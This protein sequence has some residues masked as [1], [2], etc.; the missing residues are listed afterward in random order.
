MRADKET[1]FGDEMKLKF[2]AWSEADRAKWVEVVAKVCDWRM[3][4][5][6]QTLLHSGDGLRAKAIATQQGLHLNTV[7]DRLYVI[8]TD[9]AVAATPDDERRSELGSG[10][11]RSRHIL[12]A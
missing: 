10:G 9:I 5:R 1:R 7:H 2:L 3:R 6:T 4:H 8:L 12:A 11:K